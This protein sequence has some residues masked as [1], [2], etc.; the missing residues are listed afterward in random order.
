M[1]EYAKIP[2][3]DVYNEVEILCDNHGILPEEELCSQLN[4][5]LD[6]RPDVVLKTDDDGKSLLHH[7]ACERSVDFCKLLIEK[8]AHLVSVKT[9]DQDGLLP[10]H[11]SCIHCNVKTAKYLYHLYPESIRIPDVRGFYPLHMLLLFNSWDP[12]FDDTVNDD[13]D[14]PL[15][16]LLLFFSARFN[17][18]IIA[19]TRFLLQHDNGAVSTPNSSGELPLHRAIRNGLEVVKMVYDSF[20]AAIFHENQIGRT[21]LDVARRNE[22]YDVYNIVP[23]FE[24]QLEFINQAREENRPDQYRQHCIHRALPNAKVTVGTIKLIIEAN[25]GSITVADIFGY[26]P[27]HI[28]CQVGNEEAVRILVNANED[29]LMDRDTAGNLPIHLACLAG[30]CN[31]IKYLTATYDCENSEGKLPIELLL[32]EYAGDLDRNSTEYIAAVDL[33]LRSNPVHALGRLSETGNTTLD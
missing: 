9:P 2:I 33:L 27:L 3:K 19:M 12:G 28:A 14:Y 32:Y 25:P 20:P 13:G 29:I 21:P 7:A 16:M 1:S 18:G 22:R 10:F 8:D 24:N 31:T 15:D 23:F 5:I 30:K 11:I 4:V 26:T 17:D 6:A